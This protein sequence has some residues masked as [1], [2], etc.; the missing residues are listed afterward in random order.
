MEITKKYNAFIIGVV[1][2]IVSLLLVFT[3]LPIFSVIPLG[4]LENAVSYFFEDDSHKDVSLSSFI[5]T[6]LMYA[7]FIAFVVRMRKDSKFDS[8]NVVGLMILN[9]FLVHPLGFYIYYSTLGFRGDGQLLFGIYETFAFSS[10]SFLF[11]GVLIQ[12]IKKKNTNFY[13]S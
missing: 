13:S 5:L 2:T 4:F 1:F 9:Y 11:L 6:I 7:L 12:I 10:F 8:N 3:P